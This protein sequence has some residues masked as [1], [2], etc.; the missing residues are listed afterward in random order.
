MRNPAQ[1]NCIGGI[2]EWRSPGH[3]NSDSLKSFRNFQ[4]FE[5]YRYPDVTKRIDTTPLEAP[6][7]ARP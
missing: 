2:D 4:S 1:T 6:A 5:S 7:L 3:I